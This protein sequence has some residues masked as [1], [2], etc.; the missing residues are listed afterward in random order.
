MQ[1]EVDLRHGVHLHLDGFAYELGIVLRIGKA[2]KCTVVR[3]AEQ[4]PSALGVGERADALEPTRGIL[5]L[6]HQLLVVR[7]RLSYVVLQQQPFTSLHRRAESAMQGVSLVIMI[8]H[9]PT[10]NKQGFW[11]LEVE[12]SRAGV[13]G[14]G[15][16]AAAERGLPGVAAGGRGWGE[17]SRRAAR[18]GKAAPAIRTFAAAICLSSPLCVTPRLRRCSGSCLRSWRS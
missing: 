18:C 8:A 3:H 1:R 17:P 9:S 2:D 13:Q 12:A 11:I 10:Q 7:S 15:T 16:T 6:K 14:G 4:Q 5:A